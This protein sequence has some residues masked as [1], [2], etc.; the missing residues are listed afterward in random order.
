M[1]VRSLGVASGKLILFGEHAVVYGVPALVAGIAKTLVATL[2]A[3][4]GARSTLELDHE[5]CEVG[6]DSPLARAFAAL[7]EPLGS[8]GP[9]PALEIR[10]TGDLPAAAGLGYSAAAGVAVARALEALDLERA[11]GMALVGH[12]AEVDRRVRER[13]MAWERVFHGNPSGVDVAAAM[14]GGVIRFV[15]GGVAE[16]VP[17][18]RALVVCVGLSGQRASTKDMVEAVARRRVRDEARFAAELAAFRELSQNAEQ[19]LAHARLDEVGALMN[20]AH[21]RLR[22]WELS[23]QALDELCGAAVTAGARGAKLTGKGGG[24]AVF[25]LAGA[26]GD[27]DDEANAK[28]IVAAWRKVGYEGFAVRIEAGTTNG[29]GALA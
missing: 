13:A 14:R 1:T 9:R 24:G 23:T 3:A 7:L 15:R 22:A 21:V 10:V 18:A 4:T 28:A 29:D 17:L 19:S 25:A 5:R 11:S 12:A 27:R 16:P 8:S 20:E 26:A 2:R 6:D